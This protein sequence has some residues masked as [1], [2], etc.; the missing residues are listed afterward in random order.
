MGGE[1]D[2]R[3]RPLRVSG[4]WGRP[5]YPNDPPQNKRRRPGGPPLRR[6]PPASLS[7]RCYMLP[8]RSPRHIAVANLESTTRARLLT[9]TAPNHAQ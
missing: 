6:F 4:P 3:S 5:A 8:L 9:Q 7:L 2:F 1:R